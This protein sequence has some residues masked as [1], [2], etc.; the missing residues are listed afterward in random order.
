MRINLIVLQIVW[1]RR[2]NLPFGSLFSEQWF[3]SMISRIRDRFYTIP[4]KTI[5]FP[6]TPL[7]RVGC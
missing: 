5:R 2:I 4:H 3:V 6:F 7:G 1:I